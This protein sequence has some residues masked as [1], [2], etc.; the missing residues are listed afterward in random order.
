LELKLKKLEK[1]CLRID[2]EEEADLRRK[3]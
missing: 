1:K 2:D 3:R